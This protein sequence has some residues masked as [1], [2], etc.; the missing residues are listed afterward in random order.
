MYGLIVWRSAYKNVL[1]PLNKTQ[2]ALIRVLR[3]I[4]ILYKII[5]KIIYL[6]TRNIRKIVLQIINY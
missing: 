6:F 5:V 1:E 4:I 2:R 3:K